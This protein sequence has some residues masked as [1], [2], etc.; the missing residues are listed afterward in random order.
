MTH[1]VRLVAR[2]RIE[3]MK[4]FTEGEEALSIA[5]N[6]AEASDKAYEHPFVKF[7][8]S[9]KSMLRKISPRDTEF[10]GILQLHRIWLQ[11][12][13]DSPAFAT[14]AG[15]TRLRRLHAEELKESLRVRRTT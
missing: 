7:F 2:N 8:A 13:E 9:A 6:L 15:Q 1:A 10:E 14:L 11:R 4:Y 3:A 5:F 12:A